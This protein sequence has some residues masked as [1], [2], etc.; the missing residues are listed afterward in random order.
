MPEWLSPVETL[1]LILSLRSMYP[2]NAGILLANI[3][4]VDIIGSGESGRN[5][6]RLPKRAIFCESTR[7]FARRADDK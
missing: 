5:Q 4:V 3:F 1:P 7:V 2:P 6:I